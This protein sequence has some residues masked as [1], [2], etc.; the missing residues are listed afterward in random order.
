[1]D[2]T[3]SLAFACEKTIEKNERENDPYSIIAILIT[4]CSHNTVFPHLKVW[5]KDHT[6]STLYTIDLV[7][8]ACTLQLCITVYDDSLLQLLVFG[9]KIAKKIL[10]YIIHPGGRGHAN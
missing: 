8:F 2:N 1:M 10:H 5:T 6:F 3:V 4:L 9:P 7:G